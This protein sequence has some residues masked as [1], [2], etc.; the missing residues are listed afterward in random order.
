MDKPVKISAVIITYN[1]EKNIGRCLASV[2]EVADEIVVVDSYSTDKTKEIC[3]RMNVKFQQHHFG[4]HIEQ[5]NYAVS[6][7]S[8]GHVL[9]LDADEVLSEK[10][11]QSIL[12]AKQSWRFDGYAFNRLT[13]YCGNWIRYS[14]WY[15]DTKLRL[16]DSSKGRWGGVNPHDRVMM[17][18]HSR[19]C[20][21]AGDLQHYSYHSIKDHIV[22]INSFSEIAARAAYAE[23]RKTNLVLDIVLNPL[24][25]FFKKYFLK[26]GILDG[27]QGFMIAIHTAYGKFLKYIKL[28]ELE[29]QGESEP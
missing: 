11:K 8:Y 20:H 26:L 21:I 17:D 13:N 1:E 29:K 5:K 6:C 14:G 24:L 12:A 3:S 22:Q 15:P 4:G 27:Y 18:A 9:S 25:T 19:V 7:A 10:L 2:S 16:W 23:G 28:R